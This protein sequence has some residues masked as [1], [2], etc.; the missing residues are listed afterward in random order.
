MVIMSQVCHARDCIVAGLDSL[1]Q[2][3]PGA[4]RADFEEALRLN[5]THVDALNYRALVR[6]EQGDLA[7]AL[8]DFDQAVRLNPKHYQVYN[9]RG[10]ARQACGDFAAAIADFNEAL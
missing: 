9:N 7:G 6:Q 3:D 8:A 1:E 4:A 5:P 10:L 2:G